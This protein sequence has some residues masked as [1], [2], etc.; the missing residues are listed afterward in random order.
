MDQAAGG[1]PDAEEASMILLWWCRN[2]QVKTLGLVAFA[3]ITGGIG[4]LAFTVMWFVIWSGFRREKEGSIIYR[5]RQ[6]Q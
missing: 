6:E 1:R 4:V 5:Y 2:N 3:F